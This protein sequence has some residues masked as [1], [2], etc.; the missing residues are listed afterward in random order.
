MIQETERD[1][2]GAETGISIPRRYIHSQ[3]NIHTKASRL[4]V[5]EAQPDYATG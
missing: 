2:I 1:E 5:R 4:K 3:S